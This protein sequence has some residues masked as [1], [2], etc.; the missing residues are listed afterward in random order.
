MIRIVNDINL[1]PGALCVNAPVGSG[2]GLATPNNSLVNNT[3]AHFC[4]TDTGGGATRKLYFNG[5][6]VASP[7]SGS[8][9]GISEINPGQI[10]SSNTVGSSTAGAI[11]GAMYRLEIWN[12]VFI[13]F[14]PT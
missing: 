4:Y 10:G 2:G 9:G 13:Q 7:Q 5:S 11:T 1:G 6:L 3:W 14:T 8:P 12:R